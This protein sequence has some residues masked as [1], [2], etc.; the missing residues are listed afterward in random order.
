MRSRS[1]TPRLSTKQPKVPNSLP[2][3]V[4]ATI[5]RLQQIEKK[6]A[7]PATPKAHLPKLEAARTIHQ[8]AAK[9]GRKAINL[10]EQVQPGVPYIKT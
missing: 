8:Q 4:Q 2:S 10:Q 1:L 3:R 7:D 6:I 5:N 9:V